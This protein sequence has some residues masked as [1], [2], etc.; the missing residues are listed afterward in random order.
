MRK[1]SKTNIAAIALI[2]LMTSV[3][4]TLYVP[5]HA[6]LAAEQPYSG[7]LQA[8]D[9]PDFTVKTT[10][11][12]SIRPA[13]VGVGQMI[14]VNTWVIPAPNANKKFLDQKV[15][16]TDPDG[17]TDVVTQDSYVA[18]GTTW[19]EWVVDKVG[20]WKFKYEFPGMFFP[21]GRYVL[22]DIVTAPS[23]GSNYGE[24]VYYQPSSSPEMTITVQEDMVLSWPEMP[25]PTDYWTRPV[26]YEYRE[27][28]PYIGNYPW[29]GPGG[30]ALWDELYPDTNPYWGGHDAP[31]G[32]AAG[33]FGGARGHF[34]PWVQAPESPHVAW[35]EQYTIAGILGGDFGVEITNTGIFSSGGSGRHPEI[36]YAGRAYHS[37]S[38]P[39]TGSSAVTY[40][41]CYDIR[42]GEIYWEYPAA[43]YSYLL[44]GFIPVTGALVPTAIEYFDTG[45]LPGGAVT[46]T[47]EHVTAINLLRIAGGRLYKWDPWTGA[48][49][50]NVTA[51]DG[52]YYRNGYVL[53]VQDLG[54]AAAP[55]RY[56]LINWTTQGGSGNFAGRVEG[57]ITW[58]WSSLPGTTDYNAGVAVSISKSYVGGAPNKTRIRA[59]SLTTGTELWDIAIDE[60][61][62][63]TNTCYADHGKIAILTENGYYIAFNLNTGSLAWKSEEF[64]Y[65]WD[66]PGYG[67]YNALSAYGLLYRNAYTGIYAFNWDDGT[68]AW[69]YTPPAAAPYETPYVDPDGLTTYSTNVGGAIADGK[70]YIYNTEHSATVPITR[71]WQLHCIDA[72]TG[73]GLWKVGIAG[74]SSKHT[75]NL[76]PIADG[77]LTMAGSDGFMYVF[78]KGKSATT[79][80][81]PQTEIPLG[82]G[83]MLTGTVLDMSPAQPG[84]PCV[85]KESMALQ[86]EHI[87]KQLPIAGIWGN[88]TMTGVPVSLDTVD[89]NGNFIHIGDVTTD[90]YSGTFGYMFTPEVPGTYTIMATFVGDES[91]GSSFAQTYL[92]VGEAPEPL[93]EYGTPEWPAYPE[94]EKPADYTPM[95]L[96]TIAA[97]VVVAI[98]VIYDIFR[99][100]Q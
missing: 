83:V 18:D 42:T 32:T 12:V 6:Q 5:V 45:L 22:G 28:W 60:W 46:G 80:S 99:K 27:W 79:V 67:G 78:G 66:Y 8:G 50:V 94:A 100:R 17:D 62:F 75:T 39:G 20:T 88:E 96:A 87:H 24:S 91:Y 34:T 89:P 10:A 51:M 19:F 97:I 64:D 68:I 59:A 49:T 15:T 90:G 9:V 86:M 82:Q 41:K 37:Y 44:F 85:S 95:F 69:K 84:T 2:L 63:S 33:F 77:Y 29:H 43:T 35:K 4:V 16:I 58:P 21:A 61:V 23:G 76:G 26:P 13:V 56:R 25:L 71:G 7:P 92:G 57:N 1:I 30:G 40:W 47:H 73:E 54:P 48:I 14:L 11:Y 36:V 53:S 55:D 3:M 93:P 38:K 31:A 65:P 74:A 72:T 98:L 52:T 70:Y 81:A